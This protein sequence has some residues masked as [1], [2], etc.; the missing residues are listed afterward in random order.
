MAAVQTLLCPPT[1][2]LGGAADPTQPPSS[3]CFVQVTERDCV[4]FI[5]SRVQLLATSAYWN[6]PITKWQQLGTFEHVEE[7]F[8]AAQTEHQSGEEKGMKVKNEVVDARQVSLLGFSPHHHEHL[9]A[10]PRTIPRA[11]IPRRA[12]AGRRKMPRWCQGSEVRP[13]KGGWGGQE[14]L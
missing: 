6:Q 8:A 14:V 10:S 5:R 3:L 9:R 2:S 11:E 13:E 12:A 4:D 7:Q 1:V